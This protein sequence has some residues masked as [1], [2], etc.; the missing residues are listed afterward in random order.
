MT[1]EPPGCPTPGAC[2]CA[3]PAVWQLVPKE[4]TPE[5]IDKGRTELTQWGRLQ[6]EACYRAMLAAAPEPPK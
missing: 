3:I 4:P 6:A 5:M 2:S 1:S